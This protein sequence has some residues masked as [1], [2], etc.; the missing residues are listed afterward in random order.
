M[1][2]G[3]RRDNDKTTGDHVMTEVAK[4]AP[5][6]EKTDESRDDQ[7]LERVTRFPFAHSL[8]LKHL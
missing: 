7:V 2:I 8:I 5:Q 3:Q 4:S 1:F 6:R